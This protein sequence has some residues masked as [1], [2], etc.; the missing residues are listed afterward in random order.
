MVADA[1]G[2]HV[3]AHQAVAQ[4]GVGEGRIA[5]RGE[6]AGPDDGCAVFDLA[7]DADRLAAPRVITRLEGAGE[8]VQQAD[9]RLGDDISASKRPR[10]TASAARASAR[11]SDTSLD[12]VDPIV[13]AIALARLAR[14]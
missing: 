8:K 12:P 13:I 9:F 4:R 1:G 7:R 6:G 3:F 10:S 14:V 11:A 5:R 2:V